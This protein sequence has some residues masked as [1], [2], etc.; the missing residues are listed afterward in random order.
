MENWIKHCHAFIGLGAYFEGD[1]Q[2]MWRN[3]KTNFEIL[4][5]VCDIRIYK[6][7]ICDIIKPKKL[8]E[9]KEIIWV[10]KK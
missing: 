3:T 8:R 5:P 6:N 9:P 4:S 10:P 7:K 2:M 1:P